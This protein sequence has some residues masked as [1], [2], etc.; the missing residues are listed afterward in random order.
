MFHH[1]IYLLKDEHGIAITV[2]SVF[3][4]NGLLI[5]LHQKVFPGKGGHQHDQRRFGEMKIGDQTVDHPKVVR[6]MDEQRSP[7]FSGSDAPVSV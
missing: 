5:S 2:K 1:F 3:F 4:V 6:G 7:L